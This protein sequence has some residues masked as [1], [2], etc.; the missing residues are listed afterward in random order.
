LA[1]GG[2]ASTAGKLIKEAGGVLIGFGFLI[3]LAKL[4]GR[5]KLD[6]EVL[7]KCVIKY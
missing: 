7:I 1:T 2:T 4:N 6:N 3:E 5:K